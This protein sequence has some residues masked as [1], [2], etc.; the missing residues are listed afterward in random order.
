MQS[1]VDVA[2]WDKAH[3]GVD[4]RRAIRAGRLCG[5]GGGHGN[6]DGT[7]LAFGMGVCDDRR[8]PG[9][10]GRPMESSAK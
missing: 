8:L 4:E 3:D 6:G 1:I 2:R 9:L 5:E 7:G 10:G